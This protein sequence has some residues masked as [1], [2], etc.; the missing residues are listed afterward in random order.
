[1]QKRVF[2]I[3]FTLA[4]LLL[5]A[6]GSETKE[7]REVMTVARD[8]A[9]AYFNYDF[10]KASK[11]LT[12]D[13]RKW[14]NFEASNLTEDD[15]V[16]LRNDGQGAEVDVDNPIISGDGATVGIKVSHF[17][18]TDSLAG[19]GHLEEE[20][21]FAVGLQR[22]ADGRWKV[23]MEGPL[24]GEVATEVRTCDWVVFPSVGLV[25]GIDC[26]HAHVEAQDEVVEIES[27]TESVAHGDLFPELVKLELSSWLIVVVAKSPDI[28]SVD[29]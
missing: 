19:G 6:C 28:A 17:H 8:F 25:G 4:T 9:E 29:K 24:E 2:Y 26:F 14:L 23:R 16:T 1:M 11:L 5:T 15:M 27:E 7:E 22:Q 10:D 18:V 21:T 13:S 3:I 20:A 12:D